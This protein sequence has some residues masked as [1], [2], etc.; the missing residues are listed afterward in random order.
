MT[1]SSPIVVHGNGRR[2][3]LVFG[4]NDFRS[5]QLIIHFPLKKKKGK[6]KGIKWIRFD[7]F[8]HKIIDFNRSTPNISCIF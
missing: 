5:K 7:F 2:Q 1:Y 6:N 3:R 8:K 4:N